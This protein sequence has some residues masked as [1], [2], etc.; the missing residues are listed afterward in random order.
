MTYNWIKKP[1]TEEGKSI[2]LNK[3]LLNIYHTQV[4]VTRPQ[5]IPIKFHCSVDLLIKKKSE[6]K[7][8]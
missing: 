8:N 1:E 5:Q 4:T 2:K 3:Y 7:L 6:K